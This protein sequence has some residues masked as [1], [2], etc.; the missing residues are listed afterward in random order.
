MFLTNSI[1]MN[2]APRVD[3]R[4]AHGFLSYG[5]CRFAVQRIAPLGATEPVP[6]G[7][8]EMLMRPQGRLG[9]I[10]PDRLVYALYQRSGMLAIDRAVIHIGTDWLSRYGD[11]RSRLSINVHPETLAQADGCDWLEQVLDNCCLDP[12]CLSLEIIEF[13]ET[14]NLSRFTRELRQLRE[15]GVSIA[16]DDYGNGTS[17]LSLLAEGC[18]DYLKLDRSIVSGM[19]DKRPYADLL[20]GIHRMAADLGVQTVAEG[21]ETERDVRLLEKL[22]INWAQGY[23]YSVPSLISE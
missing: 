2:E 3:P 20:F 14:V 4:K 8:H 9:W 7:W 10:A 15:L 21:V 5:E 12:A 19:H 17:N 22:G 6:S 18:V 11:G 1:A 23:Y 13:G 16:L